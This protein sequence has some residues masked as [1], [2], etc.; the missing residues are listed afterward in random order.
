MTADWLNV[1]KHVLPRARAWSITIDKKLRQLFQG[2]ADTP[3]DVQD[4]QNTVW[5]DYRPAETTELV[6]WEDQFGLLQSAAPEPDRRAALAAAWRSLGGQSPGY[7][8]G[9]VRDAG[10]DVYIHEWFGDTLPGPI[11]AVLTKS[12]FVRAASYSKGVYALANDDVV[13]LVGEEQSGVL[14]TVAPGIGT[15]LRVALYDQKLV[16]ASGTACVFVDLATGTQTDLGKADVRALD[17]KSV[18]NDTNSDWPGQVSVSY[19]SEPLNTPTRGDNP[20]FP[21]TPLAVALADEV[22]VYDASGAVPTMQFVFI[23]AGSGG[24]GDRN[25]IGSAGQ[26]ISSVWYVEGIL[27]VGAFVGGRGSDQIDFVQD[28]GTNVNTSGTALYNGDISQ[29][30][31]Q[32]NFGPATGNALASDFIKGVSATVFGTNPMRGSGLRFPTWATA[33]D[34]SATVGEPVSGGVF[35]ITGFSAQ[36]NYVAFTSDQ[37]ILTNDGSTLSLVFDIPAADTTVAAF[38]RRYY[39][40]DNAGL[41]PTAPHVRYELGNIAAA[42]GDTSIGFFCE[43]GFSQVFE[44]VSDYLLGR[45]N[46]VTTDIHTGEMKDPGGAWINNRTATD[47]AK[48]FPFEQEYNALPVQLYLDDFNDGTLQGWSVPPLQEGFVQNDSNRLEMISTGV[49]S[50]TSKAY[51]VA[52][53]TWHAVEFDF[54]KDTYTGSLDFIVSTT[55][56]LENPI[57]TE[58]FSTTD[59]FRY[60]FKTGG[61]PMYV[62]FIMTG[63]NNGEASQWDN[64]KID[65]ED[66]LIGAETADDHRLSVTGGEI[67]V[68]HGATGAD[69]NQLEYAVSGLTNGEIYDVFVDFTARSAT[70]SCSSFIDGVDQFDFTDL[71]TELSRR[72]TATGPAVDLQFG[73]TGAGAIGGTVTLD[74]LAVKRTIADASQDGES[75][76]VLGVSLTRQIAA[77][78]VRARRVTD[79]DGVRLQGTPGGQLIGWEEVPAGV[80]NFRSQAGDFTD[81]TVDANDVA[82]IYG[83]PEGSALAYVRWN[84]T[85]LTTGE[86]FFTEIRERSLLG[87]PPVPPNPGFYLQDGNTPQA[88]ANLLGDPESLLGID[89]MLLGETRKLGELLVNVDLGPYNIPTDPATWPYFLY[90]GGLEFGEF[91][92]VPKEREAEFKTLLLK[93]CPAQQWLGLFVEYV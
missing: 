8:Q 46:W 66:A 42:T 56:D 29:R 55:A 12:L 92:Q 9:T 90:W 18:D 23:A 17:I 6:K 71:G 51:A 49:G 74:N 44:D 21:R 62:G 93:L 63:G 3:A 13:D 73:G 37:K 65:R 5:Q 60:T 75:A 38:I 69:N 30:N 28:T 84:K 64:I 19:Q 54:T 2:L 45:A 80:W 59:T 89:G 31:D 76:S 16:M 36:L 25:M 24:G 11:R 32:L 20:N 52:S 43:G 40:T 22:T 34:G 68:T 57:F 47:I 86:L 85:P 58:T 26:D 87:L 39:G 27:Y 79:V 35:D 41:D 14:R 78:T 48:P 77:T 72:F 61:S 83:P 33:G 53:A 67:V 91:A 15:I 4:Y 50:R 70:Q 82:T 81:A 88:F 7:L 1:F 10:F